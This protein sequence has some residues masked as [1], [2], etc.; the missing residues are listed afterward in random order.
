MALRPINQRYSSFRHNCSHLE[1][2]FSHKQG[3]YLWFIVTAGRTPPEGT[4]KE[5][6]LHHG[7][8]DI[9]QTILE[10]FNISHFPLIR[11]CMLSYV[12]YTANNQMLLG[13][14]S[15]RCHL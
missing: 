10:G 3:T 2:E 7:D 5:T 14:F 9:I 4:S 15:P 1:R 6:Q 11:N 13:T 8:Q 12:M